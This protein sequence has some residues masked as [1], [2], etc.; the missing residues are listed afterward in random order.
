VTDQWIPN[1]AWVLAA[2]LAGFAIS[3]LFADWLRLSRRL[4]L[5]PYFAFSGAFLYGYSRWS[6]IDLGALFAHNWY[7]GLVAGFAV[8]GAFRRRAKVRAPFSI[9]AL[10]RGQPARRNLMLAT[11]WPDKTRKAAL[12]NLNTTVW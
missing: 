1:L 4:F 7:W 11:L 8:G 6:G 5:V 3:A 9:L 2:G 12:H 10:Y